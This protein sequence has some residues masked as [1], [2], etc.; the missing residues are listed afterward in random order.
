MISLPCL[1]ILD[2]DCYSLCSGPDSAQR[3]GP[4]P[5]LDVVMR[6]SVQYAYS[7]KIRDWCLRDSSLVSE[8]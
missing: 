4:A 8:R 7:I 6:G 3:D 5:N 2:S 1:W